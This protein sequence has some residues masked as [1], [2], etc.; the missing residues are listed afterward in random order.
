MKTGLFFGSFNPVHFGHMAIANFIL[1][2]AGIEQVWF[3]ISP[4]NPFK[5]KSTLLADYH[6]YELV[7]RAI[8]DDPRM[9]ASNVEFKMPKPSYTIDTLTYLSELYPGHEFWLI[10]GSDQLPSFPRWK[11]FELLVQNY[12]FIV[13]PREGREQNDLLEQ[14][15]FRIVKAPKIEISSTFIR[16]AIKEGRDV[17]H[18][19]PWAV[20]EY[21]KEMHFYE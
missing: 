21:I 2:Y 15:S 18:F 5:K 16:Q 4:Q 10:M 11:N 7:H 13:Y 6:R 17:R 9:K 8:G 20:W 3:I 19:M 12:G 14:P 1:E